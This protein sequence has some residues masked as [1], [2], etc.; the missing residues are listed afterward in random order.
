[1][2]EILQFTL[3]SFGHFIGV[4]VLICLIGSFLVATAQQLGKMGRPRK[5]VKTT[6]EQSHKL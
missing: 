6:Y 4:C 2:I 3:A 1:M 5:H